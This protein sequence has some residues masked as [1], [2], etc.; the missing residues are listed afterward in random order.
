[1]RTHPL[2]LAGSLRETTRTADILSPWDGSLVGR[3]SLGSRDDVL[4]SIAAAE[5]AAPACAALPSHAR[6]AALQAVR[7]GLLAR[8]AELA[9]LLAREAGKPIALATLEVERALFVLELAAEE[10]K[11]IGGEVLPLDLLAAG[12]G[13]WALGRRFPLAPI[14]AIT[15]FNFPLLLAVHKLAPAMACGA[16][17]VLKPPP[18]DPLVVL[19]LGEILAE[20]GYPEGALSIV[21]CGVED[22]APLVDDPRPRLLT[23]TGSAAVGWELRRRAGTKRVTLELGGN[24]AVIVEPDADLERAVA[25]IVAG[26]YAYAGQSCISVQRVLVHRDVEREFTER[27]VAAVRA[28]RPGDPLDPA[29][30]TCPLIDERSAVRVEGWIREAVA[31]GAQLATGGGRAGNRLEPGVL[32]G[33]RAGM[34]VHDEEV[35][36]PLVTVTPYA[37]FEDAAGMVNASRYGLQAGVFTRDIRRAMQAWA[38]LEV[39]AV[40]ID[41]IPTFRVDHM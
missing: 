14:S 37:R 34:A 38:A 22:A 10:A 5:R 16:S 24:A 12:E 23:F 6:A 32:L 8:K 39:G 36:A 21:P 3:A 41:D 4:A 25:R 31:Q 28:L 13:R 7:A 1:M 27:L 19:A 20:S 18:Q 40:V 15:P 11:R 9:T 30:E 35:F 33:A 2:L 29:T 26:G 17:M